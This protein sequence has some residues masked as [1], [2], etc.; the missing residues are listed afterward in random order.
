VIMNN[1]I[2]DAV[3]ASRVLLKHPGFTLVAVLA[4]A[5]G[6]GANTTIFSI[7]NALLIRSMPG[8]AEPERLVQVGRTNH[9]QGFDSLSYPNYA[10]LRDQNAVLSGL[11]AQSR[12]QFHVS[13]G[14]EPARVPGQLVSGNYFDVLGVKAA[15]GRMLTADDDRAAGESPVVVI[16]NGLW[17]RRF[18]ADPSIIGKEISLN[19]HP[20]TLVGV[21]APGFSGTDVGDPVDVWVPITMY[22]QGEPMFSDLE[23]DFLKDRG[24][25]WMS[26]FGRLK[27]GV[28]I[29]Q[30]QAEMS[31]IA[32]NLEESYPKTNKDTGVVLA[33]GLGLDP[34]SRS[35]IRGF[36]GLLMAVVGL[37]LLIACANVANLLLARATSRQKEIGIRLALGASRG[38]IIRQ[39]LTESMLLAFVS[40]AA[41][42][43]VAVWLNDLLLKILPSD[44]LGFVLSL[45]LSLDSR[46]L[47]FT[48]AVSVL[49]GIIFGLAPA[50]QASKPDLVPVL[51]DSGTAGRGIGQA[52]LRSALVVAQIALSLVLMITAGL[53]IKTL[54]NTKGINPGFDPQHVLSAR[55]DLGRQNY[56]KQQGRLFYRQ[57]IERLE[58]SPGVQSASL[59]LTMP[60]GGG[61]WGTA[62]KTEGQAAD[63]PETGVDYNVVAPRYFET[64]SM[65][66]MSGRDF[67][68]QDSADSSPVAIINE[69]LARRL[70]P[71]QDPIGKRL[72]TMGSKGSNPLMEVVGVARDAKYRTLF[73][74][75]RVQM[76]LPLLQDYH[77]EASLQVRAIGDPSQLIAGVQHEVGSLDKNLPMFRVKTMSE[78]LDSSLTPQLLA[79]KLI[80]A[81][82]VLALL[83][84]AVGIYGVMSYA[85]AQRT[86]EIGVRMA[87]GAQVGDVLKLIV[88][89]G[90]KL[91]LI[92]V[93]I[94]LGVSY[95]ITRAVESFL[96]GISPTDPLTFGLI[97]LL[98]TGVALGACLV[99]AR[100][101][102]KVDPMIALRYE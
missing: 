57:L 33:R 2:R 74:A 49:T 41:G 50:L 21:A 100:R 51:K 32:S 101:A 97:S 1:L 81:F 46:V 40:G 83:L 5:L 71:D 38:R 8:V 70:W 94:G 55:I 22:R 26:A 62:I 23:G 43:F 84:A 66:L 76:F 64:M 53:F 60:L 73:E 92:G 47:A 89:K 37:V 67:T 10:D 78:Q 30:A 45:D 63:S 35:E 11:V 28:P 29:E 86:H 95:A 17:K 27:Q 24:V 85:V 82:G 80:G 65:P 77:S 9:G 7:V 88:A 102:A 48:L 61:A 93:G 68:W 3:Y 12:T 59:A 98:L 18:G 72:A 15:T 44:Y 75:Q 13:T 6:I 14:A 19:A 91:T 16:S 79:A 58:A 52:R 69:T 39:L 36:T 56:S 25:V 20:Y 31:Q 96:Y 99:P 34:Q 42:L 90:M 87:L 54:R 4:L